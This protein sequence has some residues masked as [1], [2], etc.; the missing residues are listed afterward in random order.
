MTGCTASTPRCANARDYGSILPGCCRGHLRALM[1]DVKGLLESVH[2]VWWADYGTLL[3][4]VR[5]PL[6]SW[7]DYPWLSPNGKAALPLEPGIIP[8]DKDADLS[9]HGDHWHQVARGLTHLSHE[10]GYGL[11]LNPMAGSIKLKLSPI[12]HTNVDLFFW[13]PRPAGKLYRRRYCR[14]DQF[15]GKEF[16]EALVRELRSVQWEGVTLPAPADPEAFLAMRYGPD[17]RT[18]IPANNDGVPR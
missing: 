6:T 12:N 11:A 18:P 15:K 7:A 13:Y 3:G 8:H 14:V 1:A 16:P 5:N 17:W 4:A 2:A 9:V 10:K